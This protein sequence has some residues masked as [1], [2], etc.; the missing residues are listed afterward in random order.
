MTTAV[1]HFT[2]R[3]SRR[4]AAEG[5]VVIDDPR[6]IVRCSNKVYL[7]EVFARHRIA[8]PETLILGRE[9]ALDAGWMLGYPV[10]LKRPDSS[11]SRGVVKA[12]DEPELRLRLEEFF[13][14]SDLVVAQE[15]IPSDFDWRIGVLDGRALYA[16]K[17]FMA[18]GHWQI[19]HHHAGGREFGRV[20]TM[21]LEETP[22]G[23]VRLAE[24]AASLVGNGLYGVDIKE[25]RG[26][27][28]VM[29]INDNPN[30]DAG[31]EDGV[32]GDDL[33]RAVMRSFLDRLE[34]QGRP[35][36]PR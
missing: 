19:A 20:R 14:D 6:S 22:T 36:H 13:R 11:F 5:L 4:A 18:R 33:Y 26:R 12:A 21:P 2:Y 32:L 25:A 35:G 34:N 15:F 29:E 8:H 30:L 27:F 1:N 23:A 24:R 3:F 9:N 31:V 10:V 16:C 17:Y 28:Y 7:A